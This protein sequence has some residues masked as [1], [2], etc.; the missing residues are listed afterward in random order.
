MTG[1]DPGLRSVDLQHTIHQAISVAVVIPT[2]NR[3]HYISE[4]ILSVLGQT[5]PPDEVIVVDDGSTDG[6]ELV[7]RQCD[8]RVRYIRTDNQGVQQA[9]NVGIAATSASWIAFCD[10]DDIWRPEHIE[11][12]LSFAA[13]NRQVQFIFSDFCIVING[14]WSKQTKFESAPA[15]FWRD[16]SHRNVEGGLIFDGEPSGPRS[17]ASFSIHF[18]PIFPSATLVKRELLDVTGSFDPSLRGRKSE[19]GVFT[20]KCLCVGVVGAVA[21]ATVGIRKHAE[22][23]SGDTLYNLLDEIDNLQD[24]MMQE[25]ELAQSLH[26][27]IVRGVIIRRYSAAR[28]AFSRKDVALMRRALKDMRFAEIPLDLKVKSAVAVLPSPLFRAT[29]AMLQFASTFAKRIGIR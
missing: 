22:N 17:L 4:T 3:A 9:R 26:H 29:S 21:A 23:D 14:A 19:D 11:I 7:L 28:L 1:K 2:Y 16:V 10:S 18:H 12:C 27:S 24:F 13:R 20:L 15:W 5:R 25:R 6:T 8:G